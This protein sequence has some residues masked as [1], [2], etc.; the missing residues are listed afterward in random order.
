M[1]RINRMDCEDGS[2]RLKLE[3]RLVGEWVE[4]LREM[5]Q[6]HRQEMDTPLVLELSAVGFASRDGLRLLRHLQQEGVCCTAWAPYLRALSQ[7][8]G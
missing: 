2:V 8:G 5:C 1:L 4:L 7:C 6:H 3:G